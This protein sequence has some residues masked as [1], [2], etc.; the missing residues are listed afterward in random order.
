MSM[1]VADTSIVRDGFPKPV[2]PTPENVLAQFSLKG[3]LVVVTGAAA[4][5]GLAVT[6]AVCE[7]GAHVAMWYNT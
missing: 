2:P 6:E 3:K 4:G 5:I 1:N 7:A